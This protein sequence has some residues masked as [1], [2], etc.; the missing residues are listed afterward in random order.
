RR[1][2]PTYVYKGLGFFD[3]DEV[4]DVVALLRYLADPRSD[5]RA[6]TFLRS[7]IVRL[8]DSAIASLG[9]R[10]AA[11]LLDVDLPEAAYDLPAED[12]RVFDRIRAAL[13][14]WLGA[15]DR[16]T[17]SE[18]LDAILRET[19]YH[20]E[21]RGARRPQARENLKKLRGMI[22]RAENRGYATLQRLS[23]HLDRL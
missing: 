3:S 11:S 1:G 2:V 10:L 18:L 8:S 15:V 4:L 7:R 16:R 6:A 22:R 9:P 12:R 19:A 21:M 23:D 17:P 20:Y 14:G 5:L 13:P